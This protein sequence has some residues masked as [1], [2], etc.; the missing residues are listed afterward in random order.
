MRSCQVI[1]EHCPF[2][3]DGSRAFSGFLL[4]FPPSLSFVKITISFCAQECISSSPSSTL[5]QTAG[6]KSDL[7][8]W[9]SWPIFTL[10][11]PSEASKKGLLPRKEAL[12]IP[13]V[14]IQCA[15]TRRTVFHVSSLSLSFLFLQRNFR[16]ERRRKIGFETIQSEKR[17][18]VG[19]D[20]G[21]RGYHSA[22]NTKISDYDL[23][24]SIFPE[25]SQSA[26]LFF[27]TRCKCL[28]IEFLCLF[29]G[30]EN[31]KVKFYVSE[32]RSGRKKE[33]RKE[34]G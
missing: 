16:E 18:L 22:W 34:I 24:R 10:S 8:E 2:G 17:I 32:G 3:D 7:Q 11:L 9:N 6:T 15:L 12:R 29:A 23:V 14:S 26:L 1:P 5:T 25:M 28:D 33:E 30:S 27:K 21:F 20:I 13:L 31:G 19:R 4:H